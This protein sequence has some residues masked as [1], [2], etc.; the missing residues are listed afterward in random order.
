MI[1]VKDQVFRL[2]TK[3]TTYAFRISEGYPEHL[4]YGHKVV[5]EDFTASAL[6]NTI[7]LGCTVKTEGSSF[8]LERNLLEYSGVGRGDYRHSPSEL[9][10]PDGTFVSDFVYDSHT[11]TKGAYTTEGL[12][13]AYGGDLESALGFITHDK[14]CDADYVSVIFVDTPGSFR[15]EK[16]TT[17]AFAELCRQKI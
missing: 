11:V 7:D 17:A 14:K 6:K 9:L 4:Y 16:M 10:M 12:P 3:A 13:T 8:F 2:E 15:I 5:D 1:N